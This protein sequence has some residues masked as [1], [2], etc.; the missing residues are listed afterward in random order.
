MANGPNA[1]CTT[2]V[3]DIMPYMSSFLNNLDIVDQV[4]NPAGSFNLTQLRD[5]AGQL[6][7]V[8]TELLNMSDIRMLYNNVLPGRPVPSPSFSVTITPTTAVST[9]TATATATAT[10]TT[11]TITTQAG[12]AT[13]S[14]SLLTTLVGLLL[15]SVL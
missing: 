15:A 10:S 6:P 11:P 7:Y 1:N 5:Q 14:F 12:A 9:A 2:G 8:A 3:G 13:V 4:N